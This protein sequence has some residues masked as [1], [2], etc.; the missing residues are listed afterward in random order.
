M[1][2][3]MK[4]RHLGYLHL[5]SRA[6]HP[7]TAMAQTEVCP[8]DEITDPLGTNVFLI[9]KY[10]F[11]ESFVYFRTMCGVYSSAERLA[12]NRRLESGPLSGQ[13]RGE[14]L[15]FLSASV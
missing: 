4:W 6:K 15:C 3:S 7:L 8:R 13:A 5:L 9:D 1:S 11:A 10:G 12:R 14:T 2:A